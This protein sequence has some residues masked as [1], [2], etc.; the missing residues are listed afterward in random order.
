[1]LVEMLSGLVRTYGYVGIF[2]SSLIGSST[3]IFPVPYLLLVFSSSSVL[4]PFV[5]GIVSGLGSSIGEMTGYALGFGGNKTILKKY[6]KQI[7][8]MRKLF[9]KYRGGIGIF[10]LSVTPFPFDIV[11]IFCGIIK[12]D[13]VKFFL[14]CLGGKV[15]KHTI[16]AYAGF[17]GLNWI[18]RIFA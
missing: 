10:L 9:K 8:S 1:M 6:E 4:N 15:I 3:I 17:Y 18:F 12:Y 14:L 16:I 7:E 2:M 5:V 13:A 11:G